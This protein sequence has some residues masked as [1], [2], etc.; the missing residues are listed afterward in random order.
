VVEEIEIYIESYGEDQDKGMNFANCWNKRERLTTK[1]MAGR[2]AVRL[3]RSPTSLLF[4]VDLIMAPLG[5][6]EV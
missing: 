6:V 2:V 4:P 5:L 3:F 1:E